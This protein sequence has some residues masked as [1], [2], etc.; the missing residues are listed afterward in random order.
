MFMR[1]TQGELD[2]G[3]FIMCVSVHASIKRRFPFLLT[4][5]WAKYASVFCSFGIL[6]DFYKVVISNF[7]NVPQHLRMYTNAIYSPMVKHFRRSLI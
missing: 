5:I 1:C 3:S 6:F 7:N 2:K 4:E